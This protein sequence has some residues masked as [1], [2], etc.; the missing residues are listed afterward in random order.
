MALCRM[1]AASVISTMKVE[2]PLARSSDAPMRVKIGRSGR[3]RRG[4]GDEAAEMREQRDD[5]DLAHVGGF[6]AH[7]GAGDQ[8]HAARRRQRSVV[9]VKWSTCAPPPD[10]GRPRC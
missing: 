4:R 3:A 2:R 7:V 10:G 8:Q 9:G 1:L 6:T 5:G